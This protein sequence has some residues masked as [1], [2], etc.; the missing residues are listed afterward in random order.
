MVQGLHTLMEGHHVQKQPWGSHSHKKRAA[1]VDAWSVSTNIPWR[2]PRKNIAQAIIAD[3]I[4]LGLHRLGANNRFNMEDTE[5]GPMGGPY[6]HSRNRI[7]T[8]D[9]SVGR[10]LMLATLREMERVVEEMRMQEEMKVNLVEDEISID[11]RYVKKMVENEIRMGS[12]L[13][14]RCHW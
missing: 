7:M 8:M 1:P 2:A 12:T 11:V 6:L 10:N 13:G 3:S 9:L 14:R 5:P 4:L